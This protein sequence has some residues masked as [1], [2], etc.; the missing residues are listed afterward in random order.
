MSR[1]SEAK[2][3]DDIWQNI[4]SVYEYYAKSLGLNSTTLYLLHIIYTSEPCTQKQICDIMML[5][6]QTVNTIVRDYQN[7][8]LL[9]TTESPE[10]RRHK[11]IRLTRQG[12]AYC[13]QI[14]PP[15]E[16]AES[17]TLEQFTEEERNMMF[18]LMEK[19]NKVFCKKLLNT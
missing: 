3:L 17:Y 19:Y 14:L 13:K 7:K 16:E 2:R 5:P 15:L 9:E 11:H 1:T 8:G 18:T 6:K 10:D 12:K 4:D